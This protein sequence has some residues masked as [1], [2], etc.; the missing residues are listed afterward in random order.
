MAARSTGASRSTTRWPAKRTSC[1][2]GPSPASATRRTFVA[3]SS[4]A[5][6]TRP[7]SAA[8]ARSHA[9][10]STRSGSA[11]R[12]LRSSWEVYWRKARSP[13]RRTASR[14]S[15][16]R[17][18]TSAR[19]GASARRRATKAGASSALASSSRS[20]RT[21]ALQEGVD[22]PRLEPVGDWVCDQTR[23]AD[24]DLL[25]YHQPVLLQRAAAGGEIDDRLRQP[26]ERR[27]LHGSLDLDDLH[28]AAGVEEMLRGD[29]RVLGRDAHHPEPP[30]RLGYA[31]LARRAREHHR[32]AP[33]AEVQQLVDL[34]IRLLQQDVLAGD[35]DVGSAGRDVGRHVRRAHRDDPRLLEQQPPLVGAHRRGVE[36]DRIE[37]VERLAEQRPARHRD[38]QSPRLALFAGATHHPAPSL[39][40]PLTIIPAPSLPAALTIR[41]LG[42]RASRASI[43]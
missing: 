31:I 5:A 34:A 16:T 1:C 35:A 19:A 29:P 14:I 10:G 21:D 24:G 25:A 8:S 4:S 27:Q 40:A 20:Q 32:A 12:P 28:L 2:S 9:S 37:Q 33:V 6:R 23:A 41:P 18:A 30:Q 38:P 22:R 3:A 13:P 42:A 15:A 26:R 11:G 39:P 7:S 17:P 36:A 43:P